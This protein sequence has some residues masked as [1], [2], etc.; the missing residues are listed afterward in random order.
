M[1][2]LLVGRRLDDVAGADLDDVLTS[3]LHTTL[4]LDDVERLSK[5]LG[6][7]SGGGRWRKVNGAHAQARRF[8]TPGDD[9]HPD[10]SGGPFLRPLG[11]RPLGHEYQFVSLNVRASSEPHVGF[12]HD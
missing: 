9:V 2:V 5:D 8:F 4:A 12:G 3:G 1:P 7:P 6:V 10:I 11:G